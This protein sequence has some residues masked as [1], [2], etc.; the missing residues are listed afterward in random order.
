MARRKVA[1]YKPA[2]VYTP[3]QLLS[4][5]IA[6]LEAD[7]RCAERDGQGVYAAE[8]RAKL[9]DLRAKAGD[10]ISTGIRWWVEIDERGDASPVRL[11]PSVEE[12]T[13]YRFKLEIEDGLW[14]GRKVIEVRL[15]KEF[16]DGSKRLFD[17]AVPSC[18]RCTARS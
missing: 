15:F 14:F 11:G 6:D 17:L 4:A 9:C 7:V 10:D 18:E 8:C 16:D 12:R 1:P 2:T 13:R 3:E 5:E